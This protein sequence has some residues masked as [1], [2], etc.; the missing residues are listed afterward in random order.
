MN[1]LSTKQ[2]EDYQVLLHGCHARIKSD[3]KDF[4]DV[5]SLHDE[6]TEQ[7]AMCKRM[8]LFFNEMEKEK[9]K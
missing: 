1:T 4:Y 7:L 3:I 6:L 8:Q 5:P 2:L 9:K